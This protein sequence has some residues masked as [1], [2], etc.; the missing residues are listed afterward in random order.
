MS[1]V[2]IDRGGSS[3]RTHAQ[4][5]RVTLGR[6]TR[7]LVSLAG[8]MAL[9]A[10]MPAALIAFVGWPLPRT[11]PTGEQWLAWAQ[12]PV[13]VPFLI[14]LFTCAGWLLWAA[15]TA[16]VA[17]EIVAAVLRVDT[18]RWHLP[19]PLRA[20]ATGL[21]G[22]VLLAVV[23]SA[24]R[25]AAPTTAPAAVGAQPS[26]VNA[27]AP[28]LGAAETAVAPPTALTTTKQ[29][30]GRITFTVRGQRYH[31]IVRRGDTMSKIAKQ[32]LGDADRWP[33]IC[34]LNWHRHWPATGGKLRDC[35]LI[36]PRWDLRLPSDATP[37]PGAV[38]I[39]QASKPP[40]TAPQQPAPA[41]PAPAEPAPAQSSEQPEPD[42]VVDA[43]PDPSGTSS[44]IER[45]E[46]PTAAP[47]P[48]TGVDLPDGWVPSALAAGILAATAA[49]WA[50]RRRGH[51]PRPVTDLG[52][53]D[54]TWQPTPATIIRLRSALRHGADDDGQPH[55]TPP[56]AADATDSDP[57]ELAADA[58]PQLAGIGS[59]PAD[60]LALAG[61]GAHSAARALIIATLTSPA[62]R[63]GQVITTTA[64]ARTLFGEH[65]LQ[66][67]GLI[68]MPATADAVTRSSD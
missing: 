68:V 37:P 64:I 4:A 13:T 38:R 19:A 54:P 66:H 32:W 21:V 24:A 1:K 14:G 67:E 48:G 9:L 30:H 42:G 50:W 2:D 61:S 60:G 6:L 57:A 41:T 65:D 17:A 8:L 31:A 25:A 59:L 16:A 10:G 45:A 7:A 35:D 33:E 43:E 63:R 5:E 47:A 22:A 20:M 52:N 27:T 23:G 44:P 39:G 18:S 58:G 26:G 55:H 11:W 34:R 53:A 56:A 49:A 28:A 46:G 40:Q 3:M 29:H 36:H 62:P 51:R 15:I 12:Q